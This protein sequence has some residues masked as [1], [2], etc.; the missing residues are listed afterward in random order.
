MNPFLREA[1]HVKV[2]IFMFFFYVLKTSHINKVFVCEIY[3]I[4]YHDHDD[5]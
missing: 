1:F 4:S 3:Y 2:F 5:E